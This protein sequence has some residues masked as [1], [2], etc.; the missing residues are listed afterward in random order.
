MSII[1]QSDLPV[2][3]LVLKTLRKALQP[4]SI[5]EINNRIPQYSEITIRRALKKMREDG[6][7]EKFGNARAT[8]Y[9]L[10]INKY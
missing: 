10:K 6:K 3:K 7:I 5:K 8:K 9:G 2:D 4:L 1:N